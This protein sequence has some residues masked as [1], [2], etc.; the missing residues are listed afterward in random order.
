[1]FVE[2]RE[3][4]VCVRLKKMH[5]NIFRLQTAVVK[6]SKINPLCKFYRYFWLNIVVSDKKEQFS[7]T[8]FSSRSSNMAHLNK[9]HI[10]RTLNFLAEQ[11][12]KVSRRSKD[13]APE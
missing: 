13:I 8:F 6:E 2:E 12:L 5:R 11:T 1:M 7:Y 3:P 10:E 4:C 9:E